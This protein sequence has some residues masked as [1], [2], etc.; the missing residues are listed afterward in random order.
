MQQGLEAR[1]RCGPLGQV[2]HLALLL[3]EARVGQAELLLDREQVA[4]LAR[5][6]I[7]VIGTPSWVA[8]ISVQQ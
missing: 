7:W 8:S 5:P 3:V 6:E 4:G 2:A 1:C